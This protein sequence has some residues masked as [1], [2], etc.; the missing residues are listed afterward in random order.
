MEIKILDDIIFI[1][2][3]GMYVANIKSI[4]HIL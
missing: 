2:V 1:M 4:G 3:I